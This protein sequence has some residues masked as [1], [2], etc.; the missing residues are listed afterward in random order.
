MSAV[1]Y[2]IGRNG[3]KFQ[4]VSKNFNGLPLISISAFVYR[5]GL[6]NYI[7]SEPLSESCVYKRAVPPNGNINISWCK[8]ASAPLTLN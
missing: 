8:L 6:G 4:P 1:T 3:L 2:C 5:S 7:D